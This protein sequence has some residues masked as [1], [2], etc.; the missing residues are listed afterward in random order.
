MVFNHHREPFYRGIHGRAFRYC[1]RFEHTLHLEPEIVVKSA[2][3]VFLNHKN[4]LFALC[5]APGRLRR[6]VKGALLLVGGESHAEFLINFYAKRGVLPLPYNPSSTRYKILSYSLH[7]ASDIA[8]S[9]VLV[10][11]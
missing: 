6:F 8:I 10:D 3:I 1:P 2:C 7:T 5:F 11:E 4:E 9:H